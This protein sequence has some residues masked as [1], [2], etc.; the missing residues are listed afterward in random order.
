MY[1]LSQCK[2]VENKYLRGNMVGIPYDGFLDD[3]NFKNLFL[4]LQNTF[5]QFQKLI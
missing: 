2:S 1:I 3:F 5:L 4:K